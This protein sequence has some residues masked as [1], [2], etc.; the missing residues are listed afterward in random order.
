MDGCGRRAVHLASGDVQRPGLHAACA[1]AD[2]PLQEHRVGACRP[3]HAALLAHDT[4]RRELRPAL[5]DPSCDHSMAPQYPLSSREYPR[6]AP[7]EP[8]IGRSF[9]SAGLSSR[10]F[11]SLICLFVCLFVCFFVRLFVCFFVRSFVRSFVRFFLRLLSCDGR[12]ARMCRARRRCATCMPTY[13]HPRPILN[14]LRYSS[15]LPV[16]AAHAA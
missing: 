15:T 12:V 3:R 4:T 14:Q 2:H 11:R 7:D 5:V 8:A 9:V 6:R 16:L 1:A 10:S 13:A